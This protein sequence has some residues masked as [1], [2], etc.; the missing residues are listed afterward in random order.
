M[1]KLQYEIWVQGLHMLDNGLL[2]ERDV[3]V[4]LALGVGCVELH[5]RL[6]HLALKKQT[7]SV[8]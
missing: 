3:R 4:G 1:T 8:N 7:P 6:L 5:L 2:P